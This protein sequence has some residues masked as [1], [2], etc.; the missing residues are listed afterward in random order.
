MTRRTCPWRCVELNT[1]RS[2]TSTARAC[3]KPG[4][5]ERMTAKE[6]RHRRSARP[7]ELPELFLAQRDI[8]DIC[9]PLVI[10]FAHCR[11]GSI[12]RDMNHS[13][14]LSELCERFTDALSHWNLVMRSE[15]DDVD[16]RVV[17]ALCNVDRARYWPGR[18]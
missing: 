17:A 18:H 7:A 9:L 15:R 5:T 10:R 2:A 6:R 4:A 11:C 1:S 13:Q 16:L 14:H 8:F 12:L 3:P